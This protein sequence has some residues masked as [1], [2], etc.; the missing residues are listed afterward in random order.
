MIFFIVLIIRK[1]F[2]RKKLIILSLIEFELI[3]DLVKITEI[4]NFSIFTN[5]YYFVR[6]LLRILLLTN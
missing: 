5:F 4:K 3:L 1:Y 6:K 2:I